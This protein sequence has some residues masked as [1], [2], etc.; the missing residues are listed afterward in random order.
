MRTWRPP[1]DQPCWRQLA[2][3]MYGMKCWKRI[4]PIVAT[5][6][7]WPVMVPRYLTR[8]DEGR[9]TQGDISVPALDQL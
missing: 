8:H 1:E 3:Y 7:L 2:R 5:V 4:V 6:E 9:A